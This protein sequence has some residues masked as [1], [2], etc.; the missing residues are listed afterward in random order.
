MVTRLLRNFTSILLFLKDK[1]Q[2]GSR[3]GL[4]QLNDLIWNTFALSKQQQE[5]L[6]KN[7][8]SPLALFTHMY[9]IVPTET[10]TICKQDRC[11]FHRKE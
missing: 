9:T 6:E 5:S 4:T 3:D 8:P 10:Q 2:I 1:S 7:P 11:T